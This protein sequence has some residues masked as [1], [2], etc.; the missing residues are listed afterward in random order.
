ME[1]KMLK[2]WIQ[3][4][5]QPAGR[6]NA[7]MGSWNWGPERP[8]PWVPP[9]T[10]G[11][12]ALEHSAHTSGP[13]FGAAPVRSAPTP[14]LGAHNLEGAIFTPQL[15]TSH[16]RSHQD[17]GP[18]PWAPHCSMKGTGSSLQGHEPHPGHRQ[19]PPDGPRPSDCLSCSW[20]AQ[21]KEG[22]CSGSRETQVHLHT[23]PKSDHA[24]GW[25]CCREP[26]TPSLFWARWPKRPC[27]AQTHATG[28]PLGDHCPKVTCR[29]F[30]PLS[31][32]AVLCLSG[33]DRA[34]APRCSQTVLI[35][36][37]SVSVDFSGLNI[38][39]EA[40]FKPPMWR[41]HPTVLWTHKHGQPQCLTV[42][43]EQV[44]NKGWGSKQKRNRL[45]VQLPLLTSGVQEGRPIYPGDRKWTIFTSSR[46]KRKGKRNELFHFH[47]NQ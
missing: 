19:A 34:S 37:S 43:M 13:P 18:V 47:L 40:H 14:F 17:K 44:S 22:P 38:P 2:Y 4:A 21:A 36:W 23:W 25:P 30:R 27:S 26:P 32:L 33:S 28:L 12:P 5:W 46:G 1:V 31:W 20:W 16:S 7:D 24:W 39:T 11:S 42:C 9:A 41:P 45:M 10:G 15:P 3:W 6:K 29:S 35:L 8:G